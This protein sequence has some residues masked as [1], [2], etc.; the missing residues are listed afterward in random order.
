[1]VM[2]NRQ[3]IVS[4]PNPSPS[5]NQPYTAVFT[6]PT[7]SPQGADLSQPMVKDLKN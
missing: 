7:N 6:Q 1:M 2:D 3:P 4:G 5:P